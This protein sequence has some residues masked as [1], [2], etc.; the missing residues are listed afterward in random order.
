MPAIVL[1]SNC[2]QTQGARSLRGEGIHFLFLSGTVVPATA[3]PMPGNR[4]K[5]SPLAGRDTIWLTGSTVFEM[6]LG[7]ES[8]K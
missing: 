2:N 5:V 1:L 4:Y 8:I 6:I 7:D 3:M